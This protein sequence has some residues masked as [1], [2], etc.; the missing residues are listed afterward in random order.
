M[1][2]FF[3]DHLIANIKKRTLFSRPFGGRENKSFFPD[4]SRGR[5][6]KT[7]F[8][9]PL[10]KEDI[11]HPICLSVNVISLSFYMYVRACAHTHTQRRIHTYI[12]TYIPIDR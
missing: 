5:V 9:L 7:S 6:N 11:K 4:N 3:P 10:E 12:Y 2:L 8:I 1:K